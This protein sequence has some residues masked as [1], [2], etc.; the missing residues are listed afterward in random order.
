MSEQQKLVVVVTN[1]FQDERASVAWSIANS[2]INS[3]LEVMVFLVSSG[4]DWV[5]RGAAE[6]AQL[7]PLDPPLSEMIDNFMASGGQ[8][9]VCPPCAKV[10]GYTEKDLLEGVSITGVIFR[11]GVHKSSE[12]ECTSLTGSARGDRTRRA[13]SPLSTQCGSW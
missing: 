4:V 8:I 12:A 5:R 3:G 13:T 7:N 2:G 9:V 1:G 11:S 10:R 6:V